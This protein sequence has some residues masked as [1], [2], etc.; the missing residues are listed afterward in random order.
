MLVFQNDHL[1]NFYLYPSPKNN[2][3]SND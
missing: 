2:F 1:V 3:S